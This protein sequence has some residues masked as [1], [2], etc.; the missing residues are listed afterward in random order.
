[1][2]LEE[3][4]LARARTHCAPLTSIGQWYIGSDNIVTVVIVVLFVS[5]G[6]KL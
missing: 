4:A 6:R 3:S 5:G 1:L 2:S